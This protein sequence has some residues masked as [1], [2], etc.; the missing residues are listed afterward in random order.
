MNEEKE[1]E[2]LKNLKTKLLSA[3]KNRGKNLSE[4]DFGS[5]R[6]S[7]S[8]KKEFYLYD[9]RNNLFEEPHRDTA[10]GTGVEAVRSSAAMIF[11]LLG[12]KTV[13][14]NGISYSIPAQYD[15]NAFDA[16][17]IV[18]AVIKVLYYQVEESCYK[19]GI[20][21]GDIFIIEF[22]ENIFLYFILLNFIDFLFLFG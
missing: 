1:L 15:I 16:I 3:E 11:N 9:A 4:N 6:W 19:F 22:L 14:I 18:P 17:F 8:K 2:F 7:D 5:V 10:L 12:Q 21:F 20:P 13:V